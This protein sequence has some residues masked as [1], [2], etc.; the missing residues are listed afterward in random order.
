MA[1]T[2]LRSWSN[3]LS[4]VSFVSDV[5]EAIP[6]N[7]NLFK[8]MTFE[9]PG[10]PFPEHFI[11]KWRLKRGGICR[12]PLQAHPRHLIHVLNLYFLPDEIT[13]F[14]L[15]GLKWSL[16]LIA[17]WSLIRYIVSHTF[18]MKNTL[19]EDFATSKR[20]NVHWLPPINLKIN[21][22]LRHLHSTP[23]I[24][25]H[26]GEISPQVS[27]YFPCVRRCFFSAKFARRR[28]RSFHT[29]PRKI[30]LDNKLLLSGFYP[31]TPFVQSRKMDWLISKP[32]ITLD[33]SK[34]WSVMV[35]IHKCINISD[36]FIR[37]WKFG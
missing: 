27:P 36:H 29:C 12:F 28:L 33:A 18:A 19:N 9:F 32:V 15:C 24:K 35:F 22:F 13:S 11:T 21:I 37:Y 8:K 4:T 5:V 34:Y 31:A 16:N 30:S 1:T 23:P 7:S 26:I 2:V 10:Q 3:R 6:V 17:V 14:H 25:T 20:Q